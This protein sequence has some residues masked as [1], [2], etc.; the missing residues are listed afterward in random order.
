MTRMTDLRIKPT[1][2]VVQEA[3]DRLTRATAL[4]LRDPSDEHA[5]DYGRALIQ[6]RTA[7]QV[8][9]AELSARNNAA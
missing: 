6:V 5:T 8:L 9:A 3:M 1:D 4:Y 2:V 7:L